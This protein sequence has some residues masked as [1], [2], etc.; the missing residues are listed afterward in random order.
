MSTI[1]DLI[2]EAGR[3]QAAARAASGAAWGRAV[4]SLGNI[5][6]QIVAGNAQQKEQ[7]QRLALQNQ[8]QQVNQQQIASGAQKQQDLTT[9]DTLWADPTIYKPDGTI[10]RE[11]IQQKL[12]A[13]NAGHLAP[14]ALETADR[15]D[16]S[17]SQLL[18]KAQALR[19]SQRETLGKSALQIEAGNNDP[20]LFH[21]TVSA[22]SRPEIGLIPPDQANKYLQVGTPDEVAAITKTWK[23]GTASGQP[24]IAMVPE[25]ATP[26][27]ERTGKPLAGFTVT[28]KP[29][30]AAEL[31]KKGL[32]AYAMSLGKKSSDDLTYADR[33]Q[34]EKDKAKITSDQGFA[35]HQRERQYDNANP[36]PVKATDQ[37]T[38]EQE[39]RT[40]LAR[41]LSSR[42]GGLGLEDAKVQQANHLQTIFEQNY[43]PKTGDYNISR[44]QMN[45]LALGLARLTSPGG[46]AG[47]DMM[48]EFEQR[49]A[50]GD[51]AGAV[52]Y[53]TGQNVPANTQS[54]THMLKDSIER[55]GK[56]AETN[57]EGEMAYLRGLA[58]T[59]LEEPRR[60]AL[61]A[62]SLNAL[63][64]SRVIQNTATG[65][66]KLQTSTDGGSTW[67]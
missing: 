11:G 51:L 12:S 9:V 17:R 7:T 63:R 13:A 46:V 42:S 58:P 38:L 26:L 8:Q 53:I 40:V 52:S 19:D 2:V 14:A 41:G 24:K 33:Q 23:A 67:K 49:T 15:L 5:P 27:D 34:F 6:G 35:Q 43:D 48:K 20:G 59:E 36:T 56:T 62:T 66:R 10:N 61:E 1:T 30:T 31:T 25:G 22:L 47:E 16:E 55:Q 50:K 29:P 32:D 4:E 39:Y 57:R 64:Q 28:P 21:L 60:K 18:Q 54:L 3:N 44:V 65:E 37:N 45:E